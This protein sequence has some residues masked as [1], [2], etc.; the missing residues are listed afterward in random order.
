LYFLVVL[1]LH[2][3]RD[4]S[5]FLDLFSRQFNFETLV[6]GKSIWFVD[7]LNFGGLDLFDL[8]FLDFLIFFF[9]GLLFFFLQRSLLDF[10]GVILY[11]YLGWY[12]LYD[13]EINFFFVDFFRLSADFFVWY[14]GRLL[15]GGKTW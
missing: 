11:R 12:C 4:D 9:R 6:R 2:F 10:V 13:V 14:I 8:V 7:Q 15:G 3:V 5:F 1:G